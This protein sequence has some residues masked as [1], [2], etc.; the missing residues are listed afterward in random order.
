MKVEQ[1]KTKEEFNDALHFSIGTFESMKAIF[2]AFE[3]G[4]KPEEFGGFDYILDAAIEKLCSIEKYVSQFHR[5]FNYANRNTSSWLSFTEQL[6][7]LGD[8]IVMHPCPEQSAA[9]YIVV[10]S[11]A[12]EWIEGDMYVNLSQ[13]TKMK[14]APN[15]ATFEA[16]R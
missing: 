1:F 5:A 16:G 9:P 2:K 10:Y 12:V 7:E 4:M 13:S 3:V 15:E 6:P 14:K 11:D 8:V